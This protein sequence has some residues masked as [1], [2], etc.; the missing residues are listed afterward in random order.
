M[1]PLVYQNMLKNI[2]TRTNIYNTT[3]MEFYCGFIF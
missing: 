3:N 1:F 2:N